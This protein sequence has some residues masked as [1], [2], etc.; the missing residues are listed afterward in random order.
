[1]NP[2]NCI[3]MLTFYGVK[4][5]HSTNDFVILDEYFIIKHVHIILLDY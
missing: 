1:M 2:Y 3:Q 4:Q 5:K